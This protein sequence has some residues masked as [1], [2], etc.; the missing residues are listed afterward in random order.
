M[1]AYDCDMFAVL[2]NSNT[3]IR[4]VGGGH[5]YSEPKGSAIGPFL[6]VDTFYGLHRLD[7]GACL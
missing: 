4:M 6:H 2:I 5:G 7:I 1:L 3:Y